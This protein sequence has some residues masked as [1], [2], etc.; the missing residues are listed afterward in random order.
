MKI[1]TITK[2]G[3]NHP[4]QANWSYGIFKID[5]IDTK[6][7]Y[8][9]SYT[10]KETFGGDSRFRNI[11]QDKNIPVIETKGVYT[12]T[13]TQKITGIA[14]LTDIENKDFIAEIIAWYNKN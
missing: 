3:Y 10:V 13:G 5:T 1:I 4:S 2:I 7:Q 9:M 8:S 6:D 14:T 12:K 11:L